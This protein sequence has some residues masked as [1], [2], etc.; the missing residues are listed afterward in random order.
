MPS[1]FSRKEGP[2]DPTKD[3]TT[4]SV[5]DLMSA[6]RGL[7]PSCSVLL[8]LVPGTLLHLGHLQYLSLG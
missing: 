8:P 7:N 6:D 5:T 3:V 1:L 4:P 2:E